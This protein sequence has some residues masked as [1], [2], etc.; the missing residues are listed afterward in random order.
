MAITLDPKW[1]LNL[2]LTEIVGSYKCVWISQLVKYVQIRQEKALNIKFKFFCKFVF[3]DDK[4]LILKNLYFE[5]YFQ[6]FRFQPKRIKKKI[7]VLA[8]NYIV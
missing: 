3:Q 5:T 1:T 8:E 2:P 6:Q 4:S 7:L